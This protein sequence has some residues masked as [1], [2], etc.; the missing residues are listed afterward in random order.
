[1]RAYNLPGIWEPVSIALLCCFD[2]AFRL[3]SD[4]VQ[5][6]YKIGNGKSCISFVSTRGYYDELTILY[7]VDLELLWAVHTANTTSS[8]LSSVSL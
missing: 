1:M 3:F 7:G 4:H 5:I 2:S 8:H 6:V